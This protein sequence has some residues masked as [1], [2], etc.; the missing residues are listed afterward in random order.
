[1]KWIIGTLTVA[2]VAALAIGLSLFWTGAEST[3]VSDAEFLAALTTAEDNG[4]SEGITIHG[5]WVIEVQNPD[6][7]IAEHRE[8]SNA[9]K[10]GN[11]IEDL[12]LGLET[13]GNWSVKI[14]STLPDGSNAPCGPSFEDSG[15]SGG[16]A[17]E[18]R[19]GGGAGLGTVPGISYGLSVSPMGYP[20]NGIK[21]QG[22]VVA[23]RISVITY[24]RT[25]LGLC[26]SAI[27]PGAC[28]AFVEDFSGA[29][30]F[31][32]K[33]FVAGNDAINVAPGQKINFT[34]SMKI[35]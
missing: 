5:D 8:F 7:T 17:C 19:S 1:M 28:S 9:F 13:A 22:S 10:G 14:S 11:T 18:I 31:T 21:L 35:N 33:M 30:Q 20:D 15:I 23:T 27:G 34:I 25:Y 12:L 32:D 24:V 2:V 3:Q 29:R 6:G 26:S 4:L 16:K